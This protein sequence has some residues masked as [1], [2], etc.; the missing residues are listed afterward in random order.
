MKLR[1]F[2]VA[3]LFLFGTVVMAQGFW[4]QAKAVVAQLLLERAWASTLADGR[5]YKPWPWADHWPVAEL[6]FERQQQRHIVLEGDSGAVLAFAP[7][8]NPLS[9][10]PGD[11]LSSIISGHRDTHF[12]LLQHVQVD[13]VL[14]VRSVKA[15]QRYRVVGQQ[16]IDSRQQRLTLLPDQSLILVTCW[17]FDSLHSGGPLRL[18]LKAQPLNQAAIS[19]VS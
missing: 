10:L 6:I 4:I 19:S 16:L 12:R 9:G 5:P 7:G 11:Q 14:E 13:D 17:P 2:M 15:S 1:K 8:H 3:I 18:V